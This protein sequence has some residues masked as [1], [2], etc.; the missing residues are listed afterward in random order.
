M[1]RVKEMKRMKGM[2]RM[3]T[4]KGCLPDRPYVI[5]EPQPEG[6]AAWET[7]QEQQSAPA[8]RSRSM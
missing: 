3:R 8:T 7:G 5:A 1:K 2:K 6:S 4:R